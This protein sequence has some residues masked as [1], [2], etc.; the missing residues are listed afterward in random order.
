MNEKEQE[1]WEIEEL[2]KLANEA[3]GM[4]SHLLEEMRHHDFQEPHGWL[5]Q[6]V[7]ELRTEIEQKHRE[8]EAKE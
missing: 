2:V 7:H 3:E 6:I 5:S 1:L 8:L 4:V